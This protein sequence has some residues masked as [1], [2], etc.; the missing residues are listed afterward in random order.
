MSIIYNEIFEKKILTIV[1]FCDLCV[2]EKGI[3]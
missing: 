2:E 1:N 3:Q